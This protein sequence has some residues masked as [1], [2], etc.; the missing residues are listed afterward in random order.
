MGHTNVKDY[1]IAS[2]LA[3]LKGWFTPF[4]TTLR[5]A[6]EQHHITGGNLYN[7]LISSSF[8]PQ[9]C[10]TIGPTIQ[11]AR[12]A[13]LNLRAHMSSQ[14]KQTTLR[15]TI[16]ARSLF[17]PGISLAN[18]HSSRALLLEDLYVGPALKT[19]RMLQL[20][21][22]IPQSEHYRYLQISHLLN[23]SSSLTISL[24]W[25]IAQYY[26]AKN[27]NIKGISLFYTHLQN[28]LEF[29][30]SLLIHAWEKDFNKVY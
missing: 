4:P 10:P 8:L 9:P 25:Q 22:S 17:I 3:Q 19:F 11:A 2:I 30:K 15:F 28:K 29:K 16:S 5:A 23:Q 14:Q 26:L 1:Y 24:P 6:F 20:V 27:T 18:W 13:W 12:V 21:F 7:Y